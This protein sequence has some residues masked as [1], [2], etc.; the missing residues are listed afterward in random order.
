MISPH[1]QS[2]L[3]LTY[4]PDGSP[5]RIH[6]LRMLDI[7]LW[8]DEFCT[9]HSIPYWL[10]SGTCLGAVRHGGF[11]PWDDD[12]DIEMLAPDYHRFEALMLAHPHPRFR[13]QTRGTD[14]SYYH[15]FAKVR[16]VTHP[17]VVEDGFQKLQFRITGPFIDVFS[18]EPS[19][20]R[21][22]TRQIERLFRLS[23]PVRSHTPGASA[24]VRAWHRLVNAAIIPPLRAIS[25]LGAGERLRHHSPT[26]FMAPRFASHLLPTRRIPFEGHMLPVPARADLYL[27]SLFGPDYHRLPPLPEPCRHFTLTPDA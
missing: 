3:R 9:E 22:L 17:S 8:V 2:S 23:L 10:S 21:W 19:C 27:T 25:R 14:P 1:I 24:P 26:Y 11:I 18:L 15:P 20:S 4:N 12:I 13:L 7:L 5:L 16:D 6:Q